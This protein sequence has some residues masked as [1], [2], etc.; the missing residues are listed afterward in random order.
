LSRTES[1]SGAMPMAAASSRCTTTS[2]YLQET[3]QVRGLNGDK[4]GEQRWARSVNP[5][6]EGFEALRMQLGVLLL[7]GKRS[8]AALV[9]SWQD[10]CK[11][12]VS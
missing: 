12:L 11:H 2:A 10:L 8:S 6:Q 4:C 3:S 9:I 7:T 1:G 5:Q